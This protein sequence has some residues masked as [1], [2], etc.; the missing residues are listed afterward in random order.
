[1]KSFIPVTEEPWSEEERALYHY[2]FRI[3]RQIEEA[4]QRNDF[5]EVERLAA[6]L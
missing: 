4:A 5:A 2:R 1:M 3:T 6:L